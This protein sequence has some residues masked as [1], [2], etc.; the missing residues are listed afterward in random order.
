MPFAN[1]PITRVNDVPYRVELF[2]TRTGKEQEMLDLELP[3]IFGGIVLS[4]SCDQLAIL[5]GEVTRVLKVGSKDR[6]PL[7]IDGWASSFTHD[8]KAIICS[9]NNSVEI[10]DSQTL[11]PRYLAHR[12]TILQCEPSQN[13]KWLASCSNDYTIRLWQVDSGNQVWM[14]STAGSFCTRQV[15]FGLNDTVLLTRDKES[16]AVRDINDG[17]VIR[18]FSFATQRL[19]AFSVSPS[20]DRLA[21][22][23]PPLIHVYDLRSGDELK[24][25]RCLD[26]L[27][28]RSLKRSSNSEIES[29]EILEMAFS[30][31][32]HY[33]VV[34]YAGAYEKLSAQERLQTANKTFAR[35]ATTIVHNLHDD[36]GRYQVDTKRIASKS[37]QVMSNRGYALFQWAKDD[38][39]EI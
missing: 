24:A 32:A 35:A 10:W 34:S 7:F 33:L 23:V 2:E 5:I 11:Q 15:H 16:V 18:R 19:T 29:R 27:P 14:Q 28:G 12:D 8:G 9:N 26:P 20:G 17:Q 30:P 38:L 22:A 36:L 21:I 37:I 13:G 6:P 3:P 25:I 4:P 39:E 1:E 31:D